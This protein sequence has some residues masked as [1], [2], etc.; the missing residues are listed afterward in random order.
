MQVHTGRGRHRRPQKA[1]QV[2]GRHRPRC[3][4]ECKLS[5]LK[6]ASALGSEGRRKLIK[7]QFKPSTGGAEGESC[8]KVGESELDATTTNLPCVP[9]RFEFA[10]SLP[11]RYVRVPLER[12]RR[13]RDAPDV[14][15][16]EAS[17]TWSPL[18][19]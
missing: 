11:A 8:P 16:S 7:F 9:I 4:S 2:Y 10:R 17:T 1:V 15:N 6:I 14:A 13:V 12:S 19:R 3:D 18:K 5:A